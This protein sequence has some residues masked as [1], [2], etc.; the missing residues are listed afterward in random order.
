VRPPTG[1]SYS[2]LSNALE[3]DTELSTASVEIELPTGASTLLAT[4]T[5]VLLADAASAYEAIAGEPVKALRVEAGLTGQ[6]G[7]VL[8][9]ERGREVPV[10]AVQLA[11]AG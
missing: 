8:I 3:G 6:T 4:V 11:A 7:Y 10:S 1:A 2:A 9:T 5:Y